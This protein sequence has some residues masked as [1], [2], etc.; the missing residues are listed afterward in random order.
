VAADT[1]VLCGVFIRDAYNKA[2]RKVI[3]RTGKS[4]GEMKFKPLLERKKGE[5][6]Y[7][8]V[9]L[10]QLNTKSEFVYRKQR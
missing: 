7:L 4:P 8:K 5:T 3:D 2:E 9:F 10:S 1:G 6:V